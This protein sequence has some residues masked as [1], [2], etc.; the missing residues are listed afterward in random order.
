MFSFSRTGDLTGFIIFVWTVDLF[1]LS[2]A[3]RFQVEFLEPFEFDYEMRTLQLVEI[4]N[5]AYSCLD[6]IQK[7]QTIY[8]L[9]RA[10]C[11]FM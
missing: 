9:L 1:E 6:S 8:E 4:C 11:I 5:E 2:G 10:G 7:F 3:I